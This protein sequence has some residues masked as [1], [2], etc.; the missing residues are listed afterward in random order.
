M[1]SRLASLRHL[2]GGVPTSMGEVAGDSWWWDR[3][4]TPGVTSALPVVPS[5]GALA[6]IIMDVWEG[7]PVGGGAVQATPWTPLDTSPG[8]QHSATT[9]VGGVAVAKQ[10]GEDGVGVGINR[11]QGGSG[12]TFGGG[13]PS[14]GD[15]GQYGGIAPLDSPLVRLALQA[16][17]CGNP[18]AVALL[19]TR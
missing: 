2:T 13:S 10:Q 17:I 19:W 6:A 16:L 8:A 4:R 1:L 9:A 14:P 3:S 7:P 15:V 18:R 12:G 11:Y 5:E